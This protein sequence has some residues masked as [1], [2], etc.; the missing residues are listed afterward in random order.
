MC[1]LLWGFAGGSLSGTLFSLTEKGCRIS[2]WNPDG[3]TVTL[4]V[5]LA[6]AP[7]PGHTPGSL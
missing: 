6:P 1:P 2:S 5:T 4:P 3:C 7:L